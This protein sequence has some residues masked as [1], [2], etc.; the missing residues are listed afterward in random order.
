MNEVKEMIGDGALEK[1][2]ELKHC[3]GVT[4]TAYESIIDKSPIA[5]RRDLYRLIA[6]NIRYKIIV[7][8]EE[9][10]KLKDD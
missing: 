2:L 3:F 10:K 6:N 5:E 8:D 4:L 7:V 1:L 9:L